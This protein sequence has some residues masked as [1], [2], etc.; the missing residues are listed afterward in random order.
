MSESQD[1]R[2]Q[3]YLKPPFRYRLGY[4]HDANN[5][6]VADQGGHR[7]RGW[8]RIQYQPEPEQL[9][10]AIGERIARIL[11]EH[12]DSTTTTGAPNGE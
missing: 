9:Q 7:V 6:M 3:D 8:G 2:A 5:K 4:I 10:D 11:S 1:K 12:W